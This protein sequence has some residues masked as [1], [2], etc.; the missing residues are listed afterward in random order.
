MARLAGDYVHLGAMPIRHTLTDDVLVVHYDPHET[1][2]SCPICYQLAPR[3]T[4]HGV[5]GYTVHRLGQ[6]HQHMRDGAEQRILRWNDKALRGKLIAS[7]VRAVEHAPCGHMISSYGK[8][9]YGDLRWPTLPADGPHPP[10]PEY[11]GRFRIP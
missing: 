4:L 3:I 6:A 10:P 7:G 11:W 1:D 5:R 9:V 2:P 8:Y